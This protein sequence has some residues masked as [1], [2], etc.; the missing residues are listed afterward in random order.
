MNYLEL[1]KQF[2]ITLYPNESES[3]VAA[4]RLSVCSNC[5]E[6]DTDGTKKLCKKCGCYVG[7]KSL[8]IGSKCPLGKW[9]L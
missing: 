4:M 9:K 8:Q 1:S 2:N 5:E 6:L 7:A 3:Q